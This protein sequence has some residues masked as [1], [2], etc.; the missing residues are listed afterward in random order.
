MNHA[1]STDCHIYLDHNKREVRHHGTTDFPCAAYSTTFTNED[2]DDIPW[3]WHDELELIYIIDGE[4]KLQTPSSS[5]TLTK[6]EGVFI[7]S[8]VLHY[9]VASPV[10][11]ICSVL[12]HP[13]LISGNKESLYY[14]KY[15]GPLITDYELE[16]LLLHPDTSKPIA[17]WFTTSFEGLMNYQNNV[18]EE[19]MEFTIREDLSRI[20]L[21]IWKTSRKE[22]AKGSCS[23]D[24]SRSKKMIAYIHANFAENI[25]LTDIADAAAISTRECLR[26]FKHTIK[27]SPIQYLLHYRLS[28][29]ALMLKNDSVKNISEIAFQCGFNNASYFTKVF[30][31][32]FNLSPKDFRKRNRAY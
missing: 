11:T 18:M 13:D 17:E 3:H 2:G 28:Q 23:I 30:A 20:C 6:G 16:S 7:N 29:A 22:A 24:T 8:G 12:F 27:T 14:T 10:C 15:V 21:T 26:C 19:G 1:D 32:H 9:A 4:L 5:F 25:S 31:H